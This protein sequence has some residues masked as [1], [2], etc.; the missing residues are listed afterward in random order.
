[1]RD[2]SGPF[3]RFWESRAAATTTPLSR[4]PTKVPT[5][6][7]ASQSRASSSDTAVATATVA[8]T[9]ISPI[10]ASSAPPPESAGS[11]KNGGYAPFSPRPTC[12]KPAMEE[13]TNPRPIYCRSP[14]FAGASEGGGAFVWCAGEGPAGRDH[15]CGAFGAEERVVSGRVEFWRKG[16]GSDQDAVRCGQEKS[17]ASVP[18]DKH[19]DQ[20][21]RRA[22]GCR[23]EIVAGVVGGVL[24]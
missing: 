19:S 21:I 1:M 15:G 3:A 8:S 16:A 23:A 11:W 7:S 10:R 4:L 12:Q 9:Q 13:P 5:S 24:E 22:R 17:K 2:A 6:S 20:P 18:T 14:E